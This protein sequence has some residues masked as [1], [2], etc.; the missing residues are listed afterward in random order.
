MLHICG[1]ARGAMKILDAKGYNL[2]GVLLPTDAFKGITARPA[3]ETEVRRTS[4]VSIV[5]R[6]KG[7]IN[8][9]PRSSEILGVYCCLLVYPCTCSDWEESVPYMRFYLP[10]TIS[11]LLNL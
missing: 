5:K 4:D 11:P 9:K 6:N 1:E 2:N 8:Q 7:C 10:D 3:L